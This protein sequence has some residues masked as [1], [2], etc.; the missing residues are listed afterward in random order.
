MFEVMINAWATGLTYR[1][2][3]EARAAAADLQ[4]LFRRS[5]V[6]VAALQ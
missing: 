2:Y 5:K 6:Y 1:R 3:R 4:L